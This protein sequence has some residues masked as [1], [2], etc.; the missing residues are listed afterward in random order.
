MNGI[1]F[2]N[3]NIYYVLNLRITLVLLLVGH[4]NGFHGRNNVPRFYKQRRKSYELLRLELLCPARES[5]AYS[6]SSSLKLIQ[7]ARNSEEQ[8]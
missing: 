6:L 2:V 7:L 3:A 4:R 5:L 1:S 8:I